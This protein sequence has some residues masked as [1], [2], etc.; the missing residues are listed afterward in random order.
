MSNAN[1]LPLLPPAPSPAGA[2]AQTLRFAHVDP[3]DWQNSKKGAAAQMFKKIVDSQ[4]EWAE[5]VA[6]YELM[7]APDYALAYEHFFPGKLTL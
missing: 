2:S 6:F 7:N 4:R 5:K 1:S 3:D